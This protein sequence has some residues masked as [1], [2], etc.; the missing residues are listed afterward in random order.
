MKNIRFSEYKIFFYRIFLVYVFYFLARTCF[1]FFNQD[2]ITISGISDFF[3]IAFYGLL[4]DSSAIIYINLLFILFSLLPLW[5]N[6]HKNYQKMLIWVYFLTN[7]PAYML[8]F[9][10]IVF[11]QYNR[12]RLTVN[13]WQLASNEEN[14]AQLLFGFLSRHWSVFLIFSVFV[15]LWIFLYKKQKINHFLPKNKW[16]YIGFSLLALVFLAPLFLLGIRGVPF[17]KGTIPLT[18]TDANKYV[19]N[20]SQVNLVLN[21]PFSLIRTLGKNQGFRPY[22]FTSENYILENIQPI[23]QYKRKISEKPNVVLFILEG[24]GAEYFQIFNKEKNIPNFK[25]YTPFLD[26]LAQQGFC[27]TNAFSNAK[28]S[29]EGVTAITTGIPT[30]E[31]TLAASPYSQQEISSLPGVYN[32]MGYETVFFHGATNSSMGFNGFAKQIGY[33]KYYGRNEFNDDTHHNGSWGIHDE[34]FLQFA[35]DEI[36]KLNA[37]FLATVFTLSSHEPYTFPEKYKNKFNKGDIPMHNAVA[38]SDHAIRQFFKKASK[39]KW[40]ENTIFC[41]VADHPANTFYDYYHQKIA[42][43]SIPIFFYSANHKLIEKGNSNTL[44]QQI[45]VFPTLVDLA[46]YQQPFRSWGR[47]LFS[48]KN[49]PERAFVTD[50]N[51]YQ[52]IQGN[53]IYVLDNKGGVVGIYA[54]NDFALQENLKDKIHNREI[55]KGIADLRAFMQDFMYRIIERKLD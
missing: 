10:D 11:F 14:K 15:I 36:T 51:F 1:Y 44:A 47:S 38:Y 5:V 53:Y 45:D 3:R 33:K 31:V 40:F 52:M 13:A 30:F 55:E 19:N 24:M 48:D 23:K 21:T 12:S 41:F 49:E 37:P 18:I 17:G 8:N 46:G 26:S 54:K 28:R 43:Y 42:H 4:F 9:V 50:Q 25:S 29:M 27:F 7:I 16:R 39:E 35:S 2:V 32:K 34:P 22:N 6:T 20:L